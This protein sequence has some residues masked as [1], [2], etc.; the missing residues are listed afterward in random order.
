MR[1]VKFRAWHKE[2]QKMYPVW[3]ILNDLVSL[4]IGTDAM[5]VVGFSEVELMQFTGLVDKQGKDI[6]EGDIVRVEWTTD[7][8]TYEIAWNPGAGF[9]QASKIQDDGKRGFWYLPEHFKEMEVIGDI[10]DLGLLRQHWEEGAVEE[11]RM[12]LR[13]GSPEVIYRVDK[14]GNVL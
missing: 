5:A 9:Y 4:Q 6:Y 14:D 13:E 10:Y 12:R 3:G 2:K 7:S 11:R 8:N 1:V